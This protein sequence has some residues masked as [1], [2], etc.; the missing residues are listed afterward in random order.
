M[1]KL[2]NLG[3]PIVIESD[4]NKERSFDIYSRLLRDRI[5]F[6]HGEVNDAMADTIVAQLLLL[7]SESPNEDIVM[8]INSPGGS[9][10]AGLAIKNT[11]DFISC[12]VATVGMG[13]Q[14]SMGA[15]LLAS[16]TK[17]KR[18]VLRDSQIM[19]HQVLSGTQGQVTD[20]EIATA[21]AVLLKEKLNKYLSEYTSGKVSYE[22]MVTLCERDRWLQ[23]ED[24][25]ELG[26]IDKIIK[27]RKEL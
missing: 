6:L 13:L 24:A 4:D 22:E 12:D 20:M 9:V 2:K 7:E 10:T 23:P 21:H 17:G 5:I 16:G 1:N 14:A 25:L 19:I 8:Y 18:S 3:V 15:F 26:L 27:S 11:M